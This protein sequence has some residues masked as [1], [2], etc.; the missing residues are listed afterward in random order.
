MEYEAFTGA[1]VRLAEAE[2]IEVPH[3]ET[4]YGLLK[5]IDDS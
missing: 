5:L 2:Q 3:H 1:I 4:L